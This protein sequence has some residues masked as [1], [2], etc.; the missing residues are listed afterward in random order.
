MQK[1]CNFVGMKITIRNKVSGTVVDVTPEEYDNIRSRSR[2][3]E[4]VGEVAEKKAAKKTKP[5]PIEKNEEESE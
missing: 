2:S 3:W 1:V 4:K 5:E